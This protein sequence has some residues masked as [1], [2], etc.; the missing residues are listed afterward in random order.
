MTYTC[1]M[2]GEEFVSDWS[3]EEARAEY[4]AKFGAPY[5]PHD[6]VT[7]CDECYAAFTVILSGQP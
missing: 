2:C 5:D 3:N 7:V 6:T 1:E 4:E